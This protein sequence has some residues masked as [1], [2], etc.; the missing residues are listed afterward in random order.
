[1]KNAECV[2]MTHLYTFKN[3][4]GNTTVCVYSK[5]DGI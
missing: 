2:I 5:S 1:M 3:K 4:N